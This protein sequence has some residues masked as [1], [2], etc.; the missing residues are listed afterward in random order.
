ML[1]I[2]FKDRTHYIFRNMVSSSVLSILW[3]LKLWRYLWGFPHS[4]S[5]A[6][7]SALTPL[8]LGRSAVY[9]CFTNPTD[10][11]PTCQVHLFLREKKKTFFSLFVDLGQ[12]SFVPWQKWNEW[13]MLSVSLLSNGAVLRLPRSLPRTARGCPRTPAAHLNRYVKSASK[14][15]WFDLW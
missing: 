11:V 14:R 1:V 10:E 7:A 5:E 15:R 8:P 4:Q 13:Q 3:L 12:M 6:G 2:I 9:L